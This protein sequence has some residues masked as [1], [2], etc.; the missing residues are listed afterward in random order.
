MGG[1][2]GD[3]IGESADALLGFGGQGE[4]V[5]GVGSQVFN[6]IGGSGPK[7]PFLLKG[8]KTCSISV[9]VRKVRLAIRN[10]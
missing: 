6:D 10:R 1:S 8:G 4:E 5:F 2:L 9:M 3:L 7:G